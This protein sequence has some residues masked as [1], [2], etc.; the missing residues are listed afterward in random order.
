MNNKKV[1]IYYFRIIFVFNLSSNRLK[2]INHF[3]PL[4]KKWGWGRLK[5][6]FDEYFDEIIGTL[7]IT[8]LEF[9]EK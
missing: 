7:Q 8:K 1:F 4:C 2:I 6:E 3:P 5:K 9:Y